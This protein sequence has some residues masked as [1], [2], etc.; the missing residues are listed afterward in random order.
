[1]GLHSV[2]VDQRNMTEIVS[3][4]SVY[5]SLAAMNTWNK[6]NPPTISFDCCIACRAVAF[7]HQ[8]NHFLWLLHSV[9]ETCPRIVTSWFEQEF[10]T[11]NISR[12]KQDPNPNSLNDD[13]KSTN[14]LLRCVEVNAVWTAVD[15]FASII[16]PIL[17]V[18]PPPTVPIRRTLISASTRST[19]TVRDWHSRK[20]RKRK[21]PL[22]KLCKKQDAYEWSSM[23]FAFKSHQGE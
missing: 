16:Y 2:A 5:T 9:V 8:R 14:W 18:K 15:K 12:E 19:I 22:R 20:G 21:R 4:A 7:D 3:I 11:T 13:H 17:R 23:P 6:Y 1:M 10:S